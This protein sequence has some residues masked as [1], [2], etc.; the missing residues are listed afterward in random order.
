MHK[1]DFFFF[2]ALFIN[3]YF[4]VLIESKKTIETTQYSLRSE[5]KCV[6]HFFLNTEGYLKKKKK[7]KARLSGALVYYSQQPATFLLR[8][9]V[10]QIGSYS[11]QHYLCHTQTHTHTRRY[12]CATEAEHTNSCCPPPPVTCVT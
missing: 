11:V 10:I 4:E 7:K 9:A 1:P 6:N 3:S 8:H 12:A 2:L 5:K